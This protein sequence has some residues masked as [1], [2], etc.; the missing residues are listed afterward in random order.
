MAAFNTHCTPLK[1]RDWYML[2]AE[3]IRVNAVSLGLTYTDI[4]ARA[5]NT[6]ALIDRRTAYRRSV[7]VLRMKLRVL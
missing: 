1:G 2:A 3:G 6:A 7:A 4:H 5:A